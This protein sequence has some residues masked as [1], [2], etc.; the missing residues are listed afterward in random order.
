MLSEL[1]IQVSAKSLVRQHGPAAWQ[2][3][4]RRTEELAAAGDWENVVVWRRIGGAIHAFERRS[5]GRA[6]A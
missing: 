1:Y 6:R 5:R 3:A 2:Q 4:A